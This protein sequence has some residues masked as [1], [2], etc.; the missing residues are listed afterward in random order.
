[1]YYEAL[2]KKYKVTLNTPI[3]DISPEAV[4]AILYGTRGEKLTLRYEC[5]EG[6]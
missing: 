1:M 3:R 4:D 6:V 2:A 5:G